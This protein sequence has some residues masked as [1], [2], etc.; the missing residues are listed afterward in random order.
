M[1]HVASEMKRRG[2]SQPLLIGGATTSEIHTAVKIEPSYDK[3]VVHVKDASKAA[4]VIAS[5]LD[6]AQKAQYAARV[7]AKYEE[8]RREHS[9][10]D[11][12]GSL[13]TL[14]KARSNRFVP[15]G[16][17]YSPPR[18]LRP[19]IHVFNEFSLEELTG[20][21]D[22]TFFF[23]A[24][25]LN[26]KYP[27]VFDDPV[28][29]EEARKLFNDAAKTLNLIRERVIIKSKGVAGIFPAASSGDDVI[30]YSGEERS[31]PAATLHFLRNQ[32]LK[33]KGAPNLCLSDFIAPSGSGTDDYIGAL[34]T[35][36]FIDE[37]KM[38]EFR[39]DDYT[40]I[41]IRILA[42]RLAE[43]SAELLHKKMRQELWGF[44]PG[45]DLTAEDLFKNAFRGIRP[46]PGYPA[47]P[48]HTEKKTLFQLL[49]AEK[50]TGT[51]LTENFA[52][53]PVSS[54]SAWVFSHPRSVYFNVG[55]IGEDQLKDYAERKG[56][57]INEAARWLSPNL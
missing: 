21:I 54:V 50:N 47:C 7:A 30:V 45:E 34:V 14:E 44:S 10:G 38:E 15:S 25:K 37:K 20:Y 52:M 48:D 31:E 19:G 40:T 5:L 46:A 27:S 51:T 12:K 18:P 43:A 2:L 22:W 11:K 26:G 24:W 23:F 41:M 1:A 16:E 3:P 42:D 6:N 53:V 57:S 39:N 9:A 33:E 49:D 8:L 56:M 36:V 32:E 55:K 4:G 13:L 17:G 29:G 28:K 35:S